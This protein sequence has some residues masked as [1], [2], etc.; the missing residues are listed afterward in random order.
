MRQRKLLLAVILI[1]FLIPMVITTSLSS[2]ASAKYSDS[3]QVIPTFIFGSERTPSNLDPAN[4]WEGGSS[5]LIQQVCEGL[6]EVNISDPSCAIIPW[7]ASAMGTWSDDYL[8]YKV[9]L[10]TGITFQDGLPFNATA[11]KWS[12]DRLNNFIEAGQS[13]F[14]ELFA[15]FGGI[16]VIKDVVA[17]DCAHTLTF[18]L[19]YVYAPFSALLTFT[20]S[21]I[22]G[23]SISAP[24]S[25]YR[26]IFLSLENPSDILIGTGPF[27]YVE[28][29]EDDYLSFKAYCHYWGG[30]NHIK[31]VIQNLIFKFYSGLDVLNDA[32]INGDIQLAEVVNP[33]YKDILSSNPNIVLSRGPDTSNIEYLGM[34][35][36]LIPE[37][38]RQ[39]CSFA[40]DYD[41]VIDDIFNGM[42]SRLTSPIPLGILDH[43]PDLNYPTTDI[44]HA[45]QILIDAGYT[46]NRPD[47][48]ELNDPNNDAAWNDAAD[49]NPIKNYNYSYG[50]D[51]PMLQQIGELLKNDLH[52]IGINLT[53]YEEDWGIL[54]CK[55]FGLFGYTKDQINFVVMSWIAD[56]NDPS[57]FI[58]PFF[59]PSS[60]SNGFQVDDPELNTLMQEGLTAL[61]P[62]VRTQIYFEIQKLVVE[63]IMPWISL[64]Q[65]QNWAAWNKDYCGYQQNSMVIP[66]LATIHYAPTPPLE[67]RGLN[68]IGGNKMAILWWRSPKCD[69]DFPIL[70][71]NIYRSTSSGKEQLIATVGNQNYFIDT[72]L[73]N[74]GTYYYQI[75]AFNMK[76]EGPKTNELRI[77]LTN[78][79]KYHIF[80]AIFSIFGCIGMAAFLMKRW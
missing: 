49:I 39:A 15:P 7:L 65:N 8:T 31:P 46:S 28:Y 24:S 52:K 22:V 58:N 10:R 33:E 26:N 36:K 63:Q 76:G 72:K 35:N 17:D 55:F 77:K 16:S 30:P 62:N 80:S 61:D 19:N 6:Y 34:N 69:E 74:K 59:S 71:Y 64:T 27:A 45:R 75:S 78:K 56:Y 68:G 70:G 54:G 5:N 60:F 40:F 50:P 1:A 20:G 67:P 66:Y 51:S 48:N 21:Y 3:K 37:A 14:A 32:L 47:S 2:T 42:A 73:K 44:L 38:I 29:V 12:F 57:D 9:P 79:P 43:N 11:A 23:P 41:Y 25:P 18:H 13:S 4:A 53:L